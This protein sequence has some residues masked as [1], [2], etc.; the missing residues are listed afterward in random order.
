MKVIETIYKGYRM[1]SRLEARWAVFYDGMGIA[2]QYEVEGFQMNN[3]ER[4][5]PDFWLPSFSGGMWCEV[6]PDGGDFLKSK[7][8]AE[9]GSKQIWL[10]EGL[11]RFA[12]YK[13]WDFLEEHD[14][15][16]LTCGIPNWDQA[17]NENRM[18]WM[19]CQF[20]CKNCGTD[21][22]EILDNNPKYLQYAEWGDLKEA[23][24]IAK[25][26]RFEFNKK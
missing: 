21:K 25:Q 9:E 5:L 2:W 18:F 26:A 7:Q 20:D 4:Y 8:F 6:K 1:R 12:V 15:E 16:G 24:R 17:I 23:T 19:P 22:I 10:C 3:G 14:G 13:I 11:P